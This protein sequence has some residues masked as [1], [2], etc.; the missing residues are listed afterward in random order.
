[1]TIYLPHTHLPV[2]FGTGM[3]LY[4]KTRNIDAEGGFQADLSDED[5]LRMITE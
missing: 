4:E 5:F 2:H 3:V 1:M